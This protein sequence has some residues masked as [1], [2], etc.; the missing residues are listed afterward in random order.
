[1]GDVVYEQYVRE[2]LI[3]GG[4]VKPQQLHQAAVRFV[5]G[6]SQ[7]NVLYEWLN[8]E[9]LTSEERSVVRRGRN[10]KSGGTP[11]NL[12]VQTYRYSTAFEALIGYLYLCGATERLEQLVTEA[13]S[14]VEGR[15]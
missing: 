6:K 13:I 14:I 5:S 9:T 12:D 4:E 1:M 11:K 15:E 8:K 7:A 10:A 2:H 3:R